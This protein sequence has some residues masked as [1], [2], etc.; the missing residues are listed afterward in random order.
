YRRL[1]EA[2]MDR[3][4]K[5]FTPRPRWTAGSTLPGGDFAPDRLPARIAETLRQAPFLS[6][7]HARRLTLAYGSRAMRILGEA[8]SL[9]DLGERITGD[10]TAAEV[11][12][13]V[14]YEWARTADDVLW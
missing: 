13:L 6:A 12:Y 14:E 7:P 10:L 8:V 3:I 1:A 5:F 11:R 4:G 2:A 9:P